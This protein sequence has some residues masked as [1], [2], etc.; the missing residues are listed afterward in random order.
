MTSSRQLFRSAAQAFLALAL[1]CAPARAEQPALGQIKA[2]PA[3][4]TVHSE[5]GTAY[6]FGSL[7]LLPPNIN[8]HTP[9][10]DAAI[11]KADVFVFEAPT[12]D[13]AKASIQDFM[14]KNGLLPPDVSLPSLLNEG[15]RADYRKALELTGVPPE[16]LINKR[17]WLAGLALSVSAMKKE[18][19]SPDSGVDQRIMAIAR[20]GKKPLLYFETLQ[21]QVQLLLPSD[22]SLELEEFGATLKEVLDAKEDIGALVDAWSAG[23]VAGLGRL[24]HADLAKSPGAEKA[25]F[26]DRNRNWVTQIEKMLREPKI[27]FITVGTGHLAGPSS[28]PA[29]LRAKAYRVEGP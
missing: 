19:Y 26:T 27:Y 22:P 8:W 23:N 6:L 21:Q 15:M 7:H 20:A 10:V 17:P 24:T 12:D 11:S 16:N 13:A 4:W 3:L 18:N 9:Q 29:M 1:V 25:L 5:K 14:A 2:H 28:V